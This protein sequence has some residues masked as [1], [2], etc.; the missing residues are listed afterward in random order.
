MRKIEEIRIVIETDGDGVIIDEIRTE[1]G[2]EEGREGGRDRQTDRDR[3]TE[4]DRETG[5][6]RERCAMERGGKDELN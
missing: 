4:T 3:K 5:R 1:A 2:R 6:E